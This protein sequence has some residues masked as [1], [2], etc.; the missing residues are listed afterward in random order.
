MDSTKD[1]FAVVRTLRQPS[2]AKDEANQAPTALLRAGGFSSAAEAVVG[3]RWRTPLTPFMQQVRRGAQSVGHEVV[4]LFASSS[5]RG[6]RMACRALLGR[7]IRSLMFRHDESSQI[8]PYH[9]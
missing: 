4:V 2:S 9:Y 7:G 8:T 3:S 5:G 1:W 6:W